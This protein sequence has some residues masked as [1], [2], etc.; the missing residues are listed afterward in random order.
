V[1][2]IL[3]I[4]IHWQAKVLPPPLVKFYFFLG[5]SVC[6]PDLMQFFVLKGWILGNFWTNNQLP[7]WWFCVRRIELRKRGGGKTFANIQD[8]GLK[9]F[10]KHSVQLF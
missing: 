7:L 4:V 3:Y 8:H 9:I 1:N 2:V 6:G 5:W 10:L